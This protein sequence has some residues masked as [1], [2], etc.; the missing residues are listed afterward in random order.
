[1][2]LK[3]VPSL[4]I[5]STLLVLKAGYKEDQSRSDATGQWTGGSGTSKKPKTTKPS[6]EQDNNSYFSDEQGSPREFYTGSEKGIPPEEFEED[7]GYFGTWF[8]NDP[9]TAESFVRT[10]DEGKVYARNLKVTNP[11]ILGAGGWGVDW[12]SDDGAV[13]YHQIPISALPP[14]FKDYRDPLTGAYLSS[15]ELTSTNAVAKW[16]EV[17]GYDSV[18]FQNIYDTYHGGLKKPSDSIVVFDINTIEPRNS[19]KSLSLTQYKLK[20]GFKDDQSRSD[21]TGQ[22]TGGSGESKKPKTTKP[23]ESREF[24][25]WFLDS[26]VV[27][28]SGEPLVMY[29][30]TRHDIDEFKAGYDD[31]LL[32]FS[33]DPDFASRWAEKTDLTTRQRAEHDYNTMSARVKEIRQYEYETEKDFYELQG[34]P[35]DIEFSELSD[36]DRERARNYVEYQM[37]QRFGFTSLSQMKDK[38]DVQIYP[39][40]LSV[41][42][43]FDPRVD[44]KEIEGFLKSKDSGKDAEL[45]TEGK[46][47]AGNWI[48][49]ERPDVV[50]ELGRMGYDGMILAE[51]MLGGVDRPHDT[52]AVWDSSKVKSTLNQGEWNPDD[53]RI[54]KSITLTNFKLKA[55]F[56]EDQSRSSETGRWTG[57]GGATES[58]KPKSDKPKAK[59]NEFVGFVKNNAGDAEEVIKNPSFK[60]LEEW[61]TGEEPWITQQARAFLL[62]NGE[63]LAWNPYGLVHEDVIGLKGVEWHGAI[64][65]YID[66]I[67]GRT[68]NIF[69]SGS[70]GNESWWTYNPDIADHLRKGLAEYID[71]DTEIHYPYGKPVRDES[72]S[73]V[74]GY[75]LESDWEKLPPVPKSISLTNFKLKAGFSDSQKRDPETGMW[76][77]GGGTATEPKKPKDKKPTLT[78]EERDK[79]LMEWHSGHEALLDPTTELPKVVYHGTTHGFDDFEMSELH[80]VD[81]DWG[82][83]MYFSSN[84]FEVGSNYTATDD[85]DL[86][87]RLENLHSKLEDDLLY[88]LTD[89]EVDALGRFDKYEVLQD[90]KNKYSDSL[91]DKHKEQIDLITRRKYDEFIESI[92]GESI[93]HDSNA[94]RNLESTPLFEWVKELSVDALTGDGGRMMPMHL[95]MDNPLVVGNSD[96]KGEL[97]DKRDPYNPN[98]QQT[99]FK[100]SERYDADLDE[101]VEVDGGDNSM[102]NVMRA[103]DQVATYKYDIQNPT[104]EMNMTGFWDVIESRDDGSGEYT[105]E[106]IV[107]AVKN[108]ALYIESRNNNELA[109]GNFA[110]EVFEEMGFDGVIDQNVYKKFSTMQGVTPDTIH[111]IV[112]EQGKAKSA[113]GNSGEFSKEDTR[114]VKSLSLTN[115]RLKAGFKED[116]QRSSET[117][118]WTGSS[119]GTATATKPDKPEAKRNQFVG[120]INSAD[121]KG[122]E[123][124][125]VISNPSRRKLAEL[126]KLD[127]GMGSGGRAWL[128]DDGQLLVFDAWGVVHKHLVEDLREVNFVNAIPLY[129]YYD[130]KADRLS[131]VKV[132]SSMR[133]MDEWHENPDTA[134]FV[135]ESL[136]EYIEN[137]ELDVSYYNQS[138]VGDW[139]DLPE[140]PEQKSVK[141]ICLKAGFKEDQSRSS[142]T[143]QWTG[144]GSTATESKKP[145]ATESKE[146]VD[147]FGNSKVVDDEGEPL[148]VYHGT[149]Q[150]GFEAFEDGAHFTENPEYAGIY[151]NTN[152]SSLGGKPKRDTAKSMYPVYL[153]IENLFDPRSGQEHMRLYED[154]TR[155]Y[156]N[157]T[158]LSERGLPDWTDSQNLMDWIEGEGLSFDGIVLDEGGT[159]DGGHRGVSYVP[160]SPSQ[161]KSTNNE[162][163][164]NPEDP[165]ILKS[166]S[167]TQYKLK[168]G[169]KEDQTRSDETGQWTGGG[170]DTATKPKKETRRTLEE[171]IN[172]RGR[173]DGFG[174]AHDGTKDGV[175]VEVER[176][177]TKWEEKSAR[178]HDELDV[179]DTSLLSMYDDDVYDRQRDFM[180]GLSD[181]DLETITQYSQEQYFS[182]SMA[183]AD[184]R[185]NEWLDAGGGRGNLKELGL[186]YIEADKW[187]RAR[188]LR[189]MIKDSPDL[190][191][192]II[193]YSGTRAEHFL[194]DSLP[195]NTNYAYGEMLKEEVENV[196]IDF[197][198]AMES[199]SPTKERYDAINTDQ[200]TRSNFKKQATNLMGNRL[201]DEINKNTGV[202]SELSPKRFLSTTTNQYVGLHFSQLEN[203]EHD[204]FYTPKDR[205]TL[206]ETLV[207]RVVARYKGIKNGLGIAPLT[208]DV[209]GGNS[210]ELEVLIGGSSTKVKFVGASY[211]ERDFVD[212]NGITNHGVIYVD[213]EGVE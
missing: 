76:S 162:G 109:S 120:F 81:G 123:Q 90:F 179:G 143:G 153:S 211:M 192:G 100:T 146:F 155:S 144:G 160:L 29:H 148:V 185:F 163:T 88:S 80:S 11:L 206:G 188:K 174:H 45:I 209:H 195:K 60:K 103:I 167:L 30:G 69:V 61:S 12:V 67:D 181:D 141:S 47:K 57:S 187:V 170:G 65:L 121:S 197:N 134:T 101:Y 201:V 75:K 23:T 70:I 42:K 94:F 44:Y 66:I 161:I 62:T 116:Q 173:L 135:R 107:Q 64:P 132:S 86:S 178:V 205:F 138:N 112:W 98:H 77:G 110:R 139:E 183:S 20:A 31:G 117:G 2:N 159:P 26:Q 63:V 49:Y 114:F 5:E 92:G 122:N 78:K 196:G 152:A 40:H 131:G 95:S 213:F 154:F 25:E 39:V 198:S 9:D 43:L 202:G 193:L 97:W 15:G 108:S 54:N 59:R 172:H 24:K 83:G 182:F 16:A 212:I 210:A 13:A 71:D 32:F 73:A 10:N 190:G 113:T 176:Q 147:W 105:A 151:T 140:K 127:D 129:L 36:G 126:A 156:G 149:P 93:S 189:E 203:T 199:L 157:G 118:Q 35:R 168:A 169:F 14:D 22:W 87:I 133:E 8:S 82:Q 184:P 102:V 111:Y 58:K 119:G 175:G 28:D 6:E 37:E 177:L 106:A 17:K 208:A 72:E 7:T 124:T 34:H 137:G 38:T 1:M 136:D 41:Q 191:D 130:E 85:P 68:V 46:H 142:E 21:A 200:D 56:K 74:N 150:G 55:G 180:L 96:P 52:I 79:N 115:F 164:W 99:M 84:A 165:R 51:S 89:P 4:K 3:K 91:S 48:I 104:K 33:K 186:S 50:K 204:S 125:E 171:E 128:L 27:D 18:V 207:P 145:K 53:P 194:G 166:I 19:E 158:P